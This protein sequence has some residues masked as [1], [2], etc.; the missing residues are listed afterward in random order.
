[1]AFFTFAERDYFRQHLRENI[2]EGPSLIEIK[3]KI[4]LIFS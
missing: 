3:P 2:K 4:T 1:M